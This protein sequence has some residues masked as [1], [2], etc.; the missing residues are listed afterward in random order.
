MEVISGGWRARPTRPTRPTRPAWP[1]RP[2]WPGAGG[3]FAPCGEV[4]T[5]ICAIRAKQLQ[6]P[7]Y[8]L[9]MTRA[10]ALHL[11][12]RESVILPDSRTALEQGLDAHDTSQ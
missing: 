5:V 10:S 11:R 8:P 6:I 1:A 9:H 3:F 12:L 4:P 2:A 7:D